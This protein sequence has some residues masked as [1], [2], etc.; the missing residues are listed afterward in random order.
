MAEMS[1]AVFFCFL[2]DRTGLACLPAT[3]PR[4]LVA[5]WAPGESQLPN[6]LSLSLSA[7]QYSHKMCE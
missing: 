7:E 1:A 2:S 4:L 3:A 5:T 6:L